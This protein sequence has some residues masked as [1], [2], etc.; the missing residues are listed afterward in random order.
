MLFYRYFGFWRALPLV[1]LVF[2]LGRSMSH[3]KSKYGIWSAVITHYG[4][5]VA[6]C[7]LFFYIKWF[8]DVKIV[9]LERKDLIDLEK[10]NEL[11]WSNKQIYRKKKWFFIVSRFL[12]KKV[13]LIIMSMND[14]YDWNHSFLPFLHCFLNSACNCSLAFWQ[15]VLD[16]GR[17]RPFDICI[18]HV[19][20]FGRFL[21]YFFQYVSANVCFSP[22][23]TVHF[24][25]RVIARFWS[26]VH[27]VAFINSVGDTDE[28][29]MTDRPWGLESVVNH[30]DILFLV[31]RFF[32]NTGLV[33][34]KQRTDFI[35]E[36]HH[37]IN[38]KIDDGYTFG[39][40]Q[41]FDAHLIDFAWLI[42][43][44]FPAWI[45]DKIFKCSHNCNACF[46]QLLVVSLFHF[47][48]FK[49]IL[50]MIS[51]IHKYEFSCRN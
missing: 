49:Y 8:T 25:K 45:V 37:L 1:T 9:W 11:I 48:K 23:D 10:L 20:D 46:K 2:S 30:F 41:V 18:W 32:L 31:N 5:T 3:I 51:F 42:A 6:G 4:I 7:T 27:L 19:S 34:Q 40:H 38:R 15:L 39:S 14:T 50:T 21:I 28:I 16:D 43:G 33:E 22:H 47:L 24:C 29:P 26:Q 13:F 12:Q 35:Q 44:L 36:I 17:N